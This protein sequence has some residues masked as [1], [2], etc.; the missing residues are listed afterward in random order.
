MTKKEIVYTIKNLLPR[1]DQ[2]SKYHVNL[3]AMRCNFVWA[4]IL[5][6]MFKKEPGGLDFFGKEYNN[7]SVSTDGDTGNYYADLP[8][9][10]MVFQSNQNSLPSIKEGIRHV[11]TMT[12]DDLLFA[13]ISETDLRYSEG[14][15]VDQVK[16]TSGTDTIYYIPRFN[17]VTFVKNMSAA[18]ASAGVRMVLVIPFNEYADTD[19]LPIPSGMGETFIN[20]VLQGMAG[21]PPVNLDNKNNG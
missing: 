12:G 8:A 4:Q 13:P 21:I 19:E 6:D 16:S 11:S 2:T 10:I 5:N 7:I 20:T 3:I 1:Q 18:Q 9:P 15:E 14:L 17:K